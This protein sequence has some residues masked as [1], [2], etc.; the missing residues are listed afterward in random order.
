MNE[1]RKKLSK[2]EIFLIHFG[3]SLIFTQPSTGPINA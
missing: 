3:P 2:F 1:M